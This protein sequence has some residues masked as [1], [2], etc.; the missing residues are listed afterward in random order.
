MVDH[1]C[2]SPAKQ[3]PIKLTDVDVG[4]K[5]IE[6]PDDV[7][8]MESLAQN[9][10]FREGKICYV[11]VQ[12]H[13]NGEEE[14][15]IY[16]IS[17]DSDRAKH[18]AGPVTAP[19]GSADITI[20]GSALSHDGVLYMCAFNRNSILA[21]DM[22]KLN[23]NEEPK[24]MRCLIEYEGVPSPND[25][26]TDPKDPLS[27]YVCAGT[28]R[29]LGCVEFSNAAYGQIYKVKLD[30]TG[31]GYNV[32]IISTG[33]K[34]LAGCEII[35]GKLWMA[36]LFNIFTMAQEFSA[37]PKMEWEG[38]DDQAMVWMADNIDL[39]DNEIIL[40]PAYTRVPKDTVDKFMKRPWLSSTIL[41]FVQLVSACLKCQGLQEAFKE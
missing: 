25:V 9:A 27:L 2:P 32:Q 29:N 3:P 22:K 41:F 12:R 40:C 39:F 23:E 16:S 17:L 38:T 30:S 36:Q 33:H 8:F 1:K 24:E 20:F 10:S 37:I 21:F 31:P 4:Y 5:Y 6:F 14:S 34:T 19:D 11:P 28:F 15:H 26:C 7:F 35:N 13:V 18:V